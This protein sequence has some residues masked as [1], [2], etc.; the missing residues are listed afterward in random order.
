VR[1]VDLDLRELLSVD[2]GG[3]R[4]RFAGQRAVILDAVALGLLRKEL[5]E[6]LGA[7][8]ARAILARFGYAHGT[9]SAESLGRDFRWDDAAEWRRAGGRIHSLQ[10][11]VRVE[12]V[13]RAEGEERPFAEALLVDS[14]EAEQHLLHLGRADEPVCWTLTGFAAGY[15]SFANEREI[16]VR[17]EAC[18]GKGDPVCRLVGRF[19]EDWGG[20]ER[21]PYEKGAVD[22]SLAAVSEALARVVRPDRADGTLPE[23][24]HGIVAR[25]EAMR[26]VVHLA[27]RVARVDSTVLVSG[28]SGTGKE[29]VAALVHA[30]SARS[31]GPFVAVDCGAVAETLLESELF[32]HARGAFTGATDDRV[33]L[34]EAAN[35]GTLFLDEVGEM[36]LGMQAK[37][38]RALQEREVRRVGESRSRPVDARVVAATNRDLAKEVEAGRFRRDLYYRLAVFEIRIPPLRE[39]REDV[40]PLARRL[41]DAVSARVGR[42]VGGLSPRAADA[43]QRH[44]WA[45]NVRELENALEQ[46]AL[47]AEGDRIELEDLPE[48]VR[49]ASPARPPSAAPR[50]LADAEREIILGALAA[51]GGNQARTAAALGIGTATLYRKLRRWR[52]GTSPRGRGGATP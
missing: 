28:E 2:P 6:T 46:A 14:Y 25:S 38:L 32:G 52:A 12:P 15:L 30:R 17:E 24:R 49:A 37:L 3:G 5:I 20:R 45:G 47:L 33:G 39:R 18:V 8:A 35:G 1:L 43:L 29:R 44:P 41:L 13:P 11:L 19:R 26:R 4:I 10:G 36:S 7:T 31:G 48:S 50:S 23:E 42:K 27:E 34:F 21:M 22:A 9:R 16:V 40:L 51:H